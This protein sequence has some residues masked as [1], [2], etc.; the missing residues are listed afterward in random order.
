MA[1]SKKRRKRKSSD[2]GGWRRS[3]ITAVVS[4]VIIGLC[5]YNLLSQDS[6][7]ASRF[8][9]DYV[10]R[11]CKEVT[12]EPF[13]KGQAPH[14]CGSCSE[15]NQYLALKCNE[16]SEITANL[17]PIRNF[18][19]GTCNHF[20]DARLDPETGPHP[21]P[22]CGAGAFSESYEC[23]SCKHVFPYQVQHHVHD[24][25]APL[26][27][28]EMMSMMDDGYIAECPKC[29]KMEAY[30]YIDSPVSTCEHCDS[31]DLSSITPVSVIKWELGRKLKPNEEREVEE[32]RKANG[33]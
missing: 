15:Q 5:I 16:C 9:G 7:S 8:K 14:P 13:K 30:P 32:W 17:P 19:C 11:S 27:E 4:L 26:D 2:G 6:S 12:R 21:C 31:E 33:Q 28:D 24:P 23:L 20:E 29:K 3:P 25:N 18:T 1:T 10:C 22:K